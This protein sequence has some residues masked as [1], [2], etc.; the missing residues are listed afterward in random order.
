VVGTPGFA[1]LGPPGRAGEGLNAR[2][3]KIRSLAMPISG[4]RLI[5]AANAARQ[6]VNSA[7][8][9]PPQSGNF[10]PLSRIRSEGEAVAERERSVAE[11][12]DREQFIPIRKTDLVELLCRD[13]PLTAHDRDQFRRFCRRLDATLHCEYHARLE[14]LKDT[15]AVF[16]PDSDTQPLEL[17]APGQ[18]EEE[19]EQLFAQF[20][21]LLERANFR[22]L[23]HGEINAALERASDWGINLEVDFDVF[24]RLEI[25]ARGDVIGQRSRRRLRTMMRLEQVNLPVYQRLVVMLKLREGAGHPAHIDTDSVYIKIFKDIPKVDL[26]MLL[27]G[28]RVKL[29]LTDRGKIV[30][31][32]LSGIAITG[33]KLLQGALTLALTSAYESLALLSLVGG[34]VGYGL[35]S[36]FGYLQTKQK[37]Q[38]SLAQSLYYQNLDNN[39]GAL[40]RLLNEAEEQEFRE[41]VLGY[42]FLLTQAGEEGWKREHLDDAIEEFLDASMGI[43]VDFEIGDAVDKLVRFQLV[44]LRDDGMLR[45]VSLRDALMALDRAW[46]H[47]GHEFSA[48]HVTET[49]PARRSA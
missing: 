45:A 11:Y 18:R 12:T 49:I 30:L 37:Y 28:T 20:V 40:F 3:S 1:K 27:P 4:P 48:G 46:N 5:E 29:S 32:T 17:H 34:T 44:R 8:P 36:F 22:R 41:A 6:A 42:F 14:Q 2:I 39:A 25:F 47:A 26:E 13:W 19:I 15:Y 7:C 35:R 16:D 38:L 10:A 33:W 31:P 21:A 24:D 23:S 9:I 43:K